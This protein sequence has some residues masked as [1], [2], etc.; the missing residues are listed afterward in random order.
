MWSRAFKNLQHEIKH[1]TTP[2]RKVPTA[3]PH[4]KW[5]FSSDHTPHTTF[6]D[7]VI[8]LLACTQLSSG[9]WKALLALLKNLL[10]WW[11]FIS[12]ALDDGF[13]PAPRCEPRA[14]GITST[15][16]ASS[17]L[18]P[19]RVCLVTHRNRST[20]LSL[21]GYEHLRVFRSGTITIA[22]PHTKHK[23]RTKGTSRGSSASSHIY[24]LTIVDRFVSHIYHLTDRLITHLSSD[25][26]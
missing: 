4:N 18:A 14:L 9:T 5:V 23:Y 15:A 21:F 3:N 11:P 16:R 25:G 24:H 7:A 19:A 13:V 2:L 17:P 26:S 1:Q 8:C 20:L 12:S 22:R 10:M 6:I